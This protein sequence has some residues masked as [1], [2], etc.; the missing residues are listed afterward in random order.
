MGSAGSERKEKL[1]RAA[2]VMLSWFSR[3][4]CGFLSVEEVPSLWLQCHSFRD[5]RV[6]LGQFRVPVLGLPRSVQCV[7]S[8]ALCLPL[9]SFL[10][11]QNCSSQ[12]VA[13]T[14]C[15]RLFRESAVA[16]PEGYV[17]LSCLSSLTALPA[18]QPLGIVREAGC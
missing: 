12:T 6:G 11:F 15:L 9:M 13:R 16:E 2:L 10:S 17:F 4:D 1:L 7:V 3:K 18:W 5:V 8:W 14:P